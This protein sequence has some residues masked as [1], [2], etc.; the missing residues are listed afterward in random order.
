MKKRERHR[1]KKAKKVL[2]SALMF[3]V[4]SSSIMSTQ[5]IAQDIESQAYW[6]RD[7][8]ESGNYNY[9]DIVNGVKT[10]YYECTYTL[11]I[12]RV[13]PENNI[14]YLEANDNLASYYVVDGQTSLFAQTVTENTAGLYFSNTYINRDV[15]NLYAFAVTNDTPF[16]ASGIS[17]L[18]YN[19]FD[20]VGELHWSPSQLPDGSQIDIKGKDI[21]CVRDLGLGDENV[22]KYIEIL[23]VDEAGNVAQYLIYYRSAEVNE[24]NPYNN[25][26]ITISAKQYTAEGLDETFKPLVFKMEDA[27][28]G[29]LPLNFTVYDVE[30][31]E[32]CLISRGGHNETFYYIAFVDNQAQTKFSLKTNGATIFTN[33]EVPTAIVE[34][35]KAIGPGN[36]QIII[37]T[38]DAQQ[39][40]TATFDYYASSTYQIDAKD[41]VSQDKT[42]IILNKA[43]KVIDGI[44]YYARKIKIVVDSTDYVYFCAPEDGYKYYLNGDKTT[45]ADPL[46]LIEVDRTYQI[47]TYDVFG[48]ISN[49]R[50]KGSADDE[51]IKLT[52]EKP[53][54]VY[55]Q[56][57]YVFDETVVDFDVN[58]YKIKV[59]YKFND[60]SYDLPVET[61][62][63]EIVGYKNLIVYN[64]ILGTVTIKPYK[65]LPAGARFEAKIEFYYNGVYETEY[66][67]VLDCNTENVSLRDINNV[68][69]DMMF[70]YNVGP[71]F[72]EKV[73]SFGVSSSGTMNLS[74]EHMQDS[75]YTYHY[76]L[77]EIMNDGTVKVTDVDEV[78]NKVI[79][80]TSLSSGKYYFEIIVHSNPRYT[81]GEEVY[82]GNK[83][84]AFAVKA[85]SSELYYV[86]NEFNV[87]MAANST[88]TIEDLSTEIVGLPYNDIPLY[89]SNGEMHVIYDSTQGITL[90]SVYEGPLGDGYTLQIYRVATATYSIYLGLMQTPKTE[91]VIDNRLSYTTTEINAEGE[92]STKTVEWNALTSLE[93]VCLTKTDVTLNF[94]P[95]MT[96]VV[97]GTKLRL[98]N[99]ILLDLYYNGQFVKTF[100][101]SL[102]SKGVYTLKTSEYQYL[103]KGSGE[104]VFMFR[105]LAG[106]KH[107]FNSVYEALP[108]N[109]ISLTILREIVVNVENDGH[110]TAPI[111]NAYY[112]GEVKVSVYNETI[113]GANIISLT[114]TRNN[115][116]FVPTKTAYV[117]QFTLPGTYRL[118]FTVNYNNVT[119][120]KTL[121]FTIIN[122]KECRENINL[123]TI[124]GYK[125]TKVTKL[126]GTDVTTA[127]LKM[128][129]NSG[130]LLT[131]DKVI[132]Y[133]DE[134][135]LSAGKQYFKIDYTVEAGTYPE[136]S[137]SFAF[138]MNNEIPN[139]TCSLAPGETTTKGF[140][141]SYNA[142]IIYDQIGE[143]MIYVND[144]VYVIDENSADTLAT[145]SVTQKGNGTG[146][147]YVSLQTTS[148]NIISSFKVVVK[149][150]L[151]VW[152]I[153]IIVV[154]V[155]AVTAVVV[156][157]ILLRNKMK[158]R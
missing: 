86:E 112:N 73:T 119:L 32:D 118:K 57:Y 18:Y 94:Y 62:G 99:L 33:R 80:T 136:R 153:I 48:N 110:T 134:M 92:P 122:P 16:D 78:T 133:S 40:Y 90:Y 79:S 101:P 66:K 98:K 61:A 39:V 102:D 148:G 117:Y 46:I 135:A 14:K 50:F 12:D 155:G 9:Y 87:A 22:D 97:L 107:V 47:T 128:L 34:G 72:Y 111:D 152:A 120:T 1:I 131:Y 35:I 52:S 77:H 125:I 71:N 144:Q 70:N 82:I 63:E 56:V 145:I 138:S 75:H 43:N 142:G 2:I 45:P 8:G 68:G 19:I 51:F 100:T 11:T 95:K 137:A 58:I 105:D 88:F 13:A 154:A 74:W 143:C 21:Q 29:A 103:I 76:R 55:S 124:S 23:E 44:T 91:T 42:Q 146:D 147:Y 127:F 30:T 156:T 64:T 4:L 89:I 115:T 20:H 49:Y 126:D 38:Q 151:N 65:E 149:E 31:N 129:N 123:T 106:N 104:Y 6:L 15:Q 17:A 116:N 113:Y 83:V 28:N 37:L 85:I 60:T 69:H 158:V 3:G 25:I 141:V 5:A 26:S 81:D 59:N 157:I 7:V 121:V 41:L 150:P 140:T 24:D 114:A 53:F 54:F 36:Y 84:Y 130:K 139:I 96:D 108:S 93:E 109:Y 132:E 67:I 27:I 10:Y